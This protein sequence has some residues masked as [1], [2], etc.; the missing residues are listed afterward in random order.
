ML[1]SISVGKCTH[2][3]RCLKCYKREWYLRRKRALKE[4]VHMLEA[5][6][7]CLFNETTGLKSEWSLLL[8]MRDKLQKHIYKNYKD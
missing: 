1:E 7:N 6:A 4:L 3:D 8:T 5:N 2:E